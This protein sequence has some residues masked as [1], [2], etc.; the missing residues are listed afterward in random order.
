MFLWIAPNI[1]VLGCSSHWFLFLFAL[2]AFLVLSCLIG[3]MICFEHFFK[4]IATQID[5]FFGIL[6]CLIEGNQSQWLRHCF[7]H[8]SCIL[9]PLLHIQNYL[10]E[11]I[12]SQIPLWIQGHD[13]WIWCLANERWWSTWTRGPSPVTSSSHCCLVTIKSN[14]HQKMVL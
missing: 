4:I 11:S 13:K 2:L 3:A 14:T 8:S 5:A 6:Q 12:A 7:C 1:Y 10:V 9:A